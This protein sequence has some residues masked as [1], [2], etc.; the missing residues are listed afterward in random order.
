[1]KTRP[2]KLNLQLF[3]ED[4]PAPE[5]KK[6][7]IEQNYLKELK[8]LKENSVP[9]ADYDKVVEEH[10]KVLKELLNGETHKGG[11]DGNNQPEDPSI[12]ELRED[13]YVKQNCKNN[14]EYFSKT[15]MLREKVME[16][17]GIDPFVPVGKDVT[18]EDRHFATAAK[19]ADEIQGC[20][21]ECG[22]DPDE[23]NRLLD[24]KIIGGLPF[25]NKSIKV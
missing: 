6:D 21:D 2:F 13:L 15:L 20:I 18:P 11:D 10:K 19:I 8:K 25:P 1:M 5:D 16:Q 17:G 3:A 9:K 4:D 23:F 14:L 12:K 22:G 7:P 24:K